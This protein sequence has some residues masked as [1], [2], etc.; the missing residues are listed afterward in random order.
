MAVFENFPYTNLHNLNLD[1]LFK[2]IKKNSDDIEYIV[3]NIG[4]AADSA[5]AAEAYAHLAE[6]AAASVIEKPRR[7]V[8]IGDSYAEGY[9]PDGNNDGWA[10]YFKVDMNLPAQDF[11]SLYY[12]GI[13]F[14]NAVDGKTF[15][16]MLSDVTISD[17]QSVTDLIVAGGRNDAGYTQAEIVNAIGNFVTVARALFPI[18][19]IWIGFI[20]R[21]AEGSTVITNLR[22]ACAAYMQG[23][24]SNNVYFMSGAENVLLYEWLSSDQKHPTAAGNQ[25]IAWAMKSILMSGYASITAHYEYNRSSVILVNCT[26][27]NALGV[28]VDVTD[29]I[30]ALYMQGA[31]FTLSTPIATYMCNGQTAIP[32]FDLPIG[33]NVFAPSS[34]VFATQL[35]AIIRT[36]ASTYHAIPGQLDMV[37]QRVQLRL[38]DINDSGNNYRSLTDIQYIGLANM[39]FRWTIVNN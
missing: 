16:T 19:K 30:T 26:S 8:C 4:T 14:M 21:S 11:E 27:S 24:E 29:N 39:N 33:S 9:S 37:G 3:N 18:A 5:A 35:V 20:A 6:Q 10:Q 25:A 22:K 12:G 13:G 7:V 17:R 1:P 28:R 32:L 38:N 2:Q 23:A 15:T 36:G 31:N 34:E